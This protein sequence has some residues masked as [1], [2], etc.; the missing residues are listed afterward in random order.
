MSPD[1]IWKQADSVSYSNRN[2][3]IGPE[4]V[5]EGV[6]ARGIDEWDSFAGEMEDLINGGDRRCST[7]R[8]KPRVGA[9]VDP[10][11]SSPSMNPQAVHF[12]TLPDGRVIAFQ[13][14]FVT[15]DVARATG[16]I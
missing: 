6:S 8:W 10:K 12:W 14:Y 7:V 15:L 2:L 13:Q 4:A 1:I 5:A 11:L 16:N 3:S 9:E